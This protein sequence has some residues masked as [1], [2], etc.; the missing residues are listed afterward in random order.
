MNVPDRRG[1]TVGIVLVGLGIFFILRREL[2]LS[3]PGPILLVI[4]AILFTLSALRS[5]RGPVLPASVLLGLGAGFLLR[6]P[7]EP[8]VPPWATILLGIGCGL[9][10]AAGIDRQAGHEQRPS[11]LIPGV[12]LVTIAAAAALATNVRV[13]E[14]VIDAVW[15]LWPWALV[16]A[17]VILVVQGVR[18]RA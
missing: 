17:G 18:R 9:L 7:L 3:G 8:W 10:L 13:S 11:T 5:F 12:V 6:D 1:L 14:N 2:H 4:G 16:L 15:R